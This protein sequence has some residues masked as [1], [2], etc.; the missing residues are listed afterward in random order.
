MVCFFSSTR[1]SL[2]SG[3]DNWNLVMLCTNKICPNAKKIAI[4]I[5]FLQR[6]Y[7]SRDAYTVYTAWETTCDPLIC[8]Q[9]TACDACDPLVCVEETACDTF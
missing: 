5:G 8:V 4:I 7:M 2:G 1:G 6:D 3:L 9:E